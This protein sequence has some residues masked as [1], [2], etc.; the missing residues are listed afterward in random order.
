MIGAVTATA[1]S[2]ARGRCLQR[3]TRRRAASAITRPGRVGLTRIERTWRAVPPG[4]DGD[5]ASTTVLA[6]G[7]PDLEGATERVA[8][9]VSGLGVGRR[10]QDRVDAA[11]RQ[12]DR[13]RQHELVVE[14]EAGGHQ[15]E[16]APG[17]AMQACAG[18]EA[19][20]GRKQGHRGAEQPRARGEQQRSRHDG[21]RREQPQQRDRPQEQRARRSQRE[22]SLVSVGRAVHEP[23]ADLAAEREERDDGGRCEPEYE[24]RHRRAGHPG[25][26]GHED[27]ARCDHAHDRQAHGVR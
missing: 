2:A 27:G 3:A 13:F 25:G 4:L 19:E 21:G 26:E 16:P 10:Q 14:D 9:E 23:L 11:L 20:A 6:S 22:S 5:P 8:G 18:H 12:H 15:D 7:E 1:F 24:R 17:E